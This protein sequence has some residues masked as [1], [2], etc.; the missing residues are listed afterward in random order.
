M[1]QFQNC[2]IYRTIIFDILIKRNILQKFVQSFD[3][4]IIEIMNDK[5]SEKVVEIPIL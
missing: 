3:L 5:T 1:R 2:F 4:E